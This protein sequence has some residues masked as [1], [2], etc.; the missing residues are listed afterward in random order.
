AAADHRERVRRRKERRS[1][2]D[3]DGLL[4]RVDEIGVDLVLRRVRSEAEDAVLGLEN[5]L[6]AERDVIRDQRRHADA[7]V[8]GVTVAKLAD[9][10]P[11]DAFAV[12]HLRSSLNLRAR[13][14]HFFLTVLRSIRFSRGA[15]RTRF[16]K[17]PGVWTH[18]GSSSPTSTSSSTS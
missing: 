16:T 14:A 7:E 15:T 17:T 12:E 10:S 11:D 8:D 1:G 6:H 4:A 18:S 13:A 2:P 3:R 9:G 5:D